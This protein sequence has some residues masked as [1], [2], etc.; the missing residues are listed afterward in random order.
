MLTLWLRAGL[1]LTLMDVTVHAQHSLVWTTSLPPLWDRHL[2]LV[3]ETEELQCTSA[4]SF[5]PTLMVVSGSGEHVI[6]SLTLPLAITPARFFTSSQ[7]ALTVVLIAAPHCS[8][9]VRT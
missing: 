6:T 7:E 9:R 2:P 3:I 5:S 4:P 8:Y 1:G